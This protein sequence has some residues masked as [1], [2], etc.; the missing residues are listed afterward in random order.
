MISFHSYVGL[1]EGTPFF[2]FF[3][4]FAWMMAFLF[5]YMNPRIAFPKLAKLSQDRSTTGNLRFRKEDSEIPKSI[6]VEKNITL[7]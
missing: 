5:V 6:Q 1:P 3:S 7:F 4:F 2:L